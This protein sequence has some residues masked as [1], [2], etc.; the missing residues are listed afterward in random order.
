MRHEL[1][2]VG[3]AST[4]TEEMKAILSFVVFI[5]LTTIIQRD[6]KREREREREGS[7]LQSNRNY[8]QL[9]NNPTCQ[10]M[11]HNGLDI[12]H[13]KYMH[14]S[15]CVAFESKYRSLCNV[16]REKQRVEYNLFIVACLAFLLFRFFSNCA[17]MNNDKTSMSTSRD[18]HRVVNILYVRELPLGTS[19]RQ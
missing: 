13:I 12:I 17:K 4:T 2:L 9:T 3:V 10:L 5:L 6:G 7:I 16:S 19:L 18:V 15:R 1:L 8:F 11:N 14:I